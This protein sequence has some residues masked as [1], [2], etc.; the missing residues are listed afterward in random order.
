MRETKSNDQPCEGDEATPEGTRSE[1]PKGKK[2]DL[3]SS[4]KQSKETY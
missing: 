2:I 4:G 3:S 1:V